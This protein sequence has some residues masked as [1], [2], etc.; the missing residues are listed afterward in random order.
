VYGLFTDECEA[1]ERL[2]P[3]FN[4]DEIFGTVINRFVVQAAAGYPLTVYGKGGQRRGY[5]NIKDTLQ[6]I[7]LAV[8]NPPAAGELRIFNQF[9]ETF[10]VNELAYRI[11]DVAARMGL[12]VSIQHMENPRKEA[13]NHYYNPAHQGF[14]ALGLIPHYLT[15]DVLVKMMK[16]V[17]KYQ[18]EIDRE[19]IFRNVKWA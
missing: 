2:L 6:C 19:K 4:Y 15:E 3:F 12:K 8:T 10:S 5:I 9:T 18:S 14:K 13:E 11:K 7:D 17:I 1:E 16:F